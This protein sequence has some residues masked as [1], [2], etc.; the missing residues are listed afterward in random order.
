MI[1]FANTLG[2]AQ[3]LMWALIAFCVHIKLSSNSSKIDM[4]SQNKDKPCIMYNYE[5]LETI[6]SFKYLCL[7][8]SSNYNWNECAT[9]C[10]ETRKTTYYAIG[11]TYNH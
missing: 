10:L 6:Y 5:P 1:H 9:P 8:V 11:N 7:E 2:D 4:K 3:K